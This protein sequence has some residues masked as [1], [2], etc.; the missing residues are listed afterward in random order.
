MKNAFFLCDEA[1]FPIGHI[2]CHMLLRNSGRL[3]KSSPAA[4]MHLISK[5]PSAT[6]G[7]HCTPFT[8][9]LGRIQQRMNPSLKKEAEAILE[10]QGIKPSQAI[11]LFY[12]EVKRFGGLPFHP[13]PVHPSEIPNAKLQKDIRDAR[14]G[15]GIRTFKSEKEFFDSLR[16]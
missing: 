1:K 8:M 16:R 5:R 9:A 13:S 14:R 7:V 15:K 11:I 10:M 12:M 2:T 6:I 4:S 3:M